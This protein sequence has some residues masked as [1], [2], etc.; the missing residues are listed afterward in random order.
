MKN[1]HI[2]NTISAKLTMMGFKDVNAN[3]KIITLSDT[4][5]IYLTLNIQA[6]YFHI[7]NTLSNN[8]KIPI[9]KN[10]IPEIIKYIDEYSTYDI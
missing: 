4:Q 9:G 10:T 8:Q 1:K 3:L 6:N 7:T 5:T 2:I